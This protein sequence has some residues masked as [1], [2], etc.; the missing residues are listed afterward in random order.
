MDPT[1]LAARFEQWRRD[2]DLDALA[3]VFDATAPELLRVAAHLMHDDHAA[4]DLVQ[5]TFLE[6]LRQPQRF[7]AGAPL[8]PWLVG[9]LTRQAHKLRRSRDRRPD[10]LR[11]RGGGVAPASDPLAGSELD[12]AV[13]RALATMPEPYASVVRAHLHDGVRPAEL[14]ARRGCPAGTIRMQLSRGLSLLRQALPAGLVLPLALRRAEAISRVRDVVLARATAPAGLAGLLLGATA[15]KLAAGLALAAA[16]VASWIWWVGRLAPVLPPIP[17]PGAQAVVGATAADFVRTQPSPPTHHAGDVAAGGDL[18][19]TVVRDRPAP[20]W[21]LVGTVRLPGGD[22][23]VGATVE[24]GLWGHG[25]RST[26]VVDADGAFVLDLTPLVLPPAAPSPGW[27]LLLPAPTQRGPQLLH[28]N[29]RHPACITAMAMHQLDAAAPAPPTGRI[30][31]VQDFHLR[32]AARVVGRVVAPAGERAAAAQVAAFAAER[33]AASVAEPLAS[34]EVDDDGAFAFELETGGAIELWIDHPRLLPLAV[35]ATAV[36]GTVTDVGELQIEPSA[37][38]IR[39]R[40]EVAGAAAGAIDVWLQRTGMS[41]TRST[42]TLFGGLARVDGDLIDTLRDVR[43]DGDGRFDAAGLVAGPWLLKLGHVPDLPLCP[44]DAGVIVVAPAAAVVLG[45]DR[46]RLLLEVHGAHGPLAGVR[47]R[48]RCGD[49]V[50]ELATDAAGRASWLGT[51][52]ADYEVALDHPH[53]AR[54]TLAWPATERTHAGNRRIELR[55]QASASLTLR[56]DEPP[57]TEP[58]VQV[59]LHRRNAGA[60]ATDGSAIEPAADLATTVVDGEIRI[61]GL[62]DGAFAVRIAPRHASGLPFAVT[63]RPTATVAVDVDLRMGACTT[64]HVTR[65]AVGRL[66]LD[67]RAPAG[68]SATLGRLRL[69]DARGR[70]MATTTVI[71]RPSGWLE[72]AGRVD[73]AGSNTLCPD[74]PPGR[75]TVVAEHPTLGEHRFDVEIAAGEVTRRSLPP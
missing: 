58:D 19:R 41:G 33:L 15:A 24:A 28:V 48:V 75:Y 27:P 55:P 60:A 66:R 8:V 34:A 5:T 56:L 36:L 53:H 52:A 30:E 62:P 10:P 6:V 72:T 73:F 14:A 2:R 17:P 29:A 22:A 37:V 26:A 40:V 71:D 59:T 18:A 35:P 20:G 47:V 64:V 42:S 67:G 32:A 61:D 69:F 4:H 3:D 51:A 23:A 7:R 54:A 45:A 16:A 57:G 44:P 25:Q 46:V 43:C 74:L 13:A 63:G 38:S 68:P 11:L 12:D 21:W 1:T 49:A 50:I 70:P 31:V 65:P 39:G 9:I